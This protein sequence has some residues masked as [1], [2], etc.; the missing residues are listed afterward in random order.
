MNP[1]A[2]DADILN[3][4]A[5]AMK[6]TTQPTLV[7]EGPLDGPG[8]TPVLVY[9]CPVPRDREFAAGCLYVVVEK[10]ADGE[11]PIQAADITNEYL[12]GRPLAPPI[13]MA[14]TLDDA[15]ADARLHR[16]IA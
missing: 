2:S 3:G 13:G 4:I 11:M 15:L 9:D 5:A 12:V 1:M 7:Y 14:N 8:S 10:P 16:A 6:K